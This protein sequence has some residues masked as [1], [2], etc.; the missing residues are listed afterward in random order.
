MRTII[1]ASILAFTCCLKANA[2]EIKPVSWTYVANKTGQ[3]EAEIYITAIIDR[4]YKI[5]SL[6]MEDGGP[7]KT[8]IVFRPSKAYKL[9]GNI[10]EPVPINVYSDVFKMNISYFEEK[11]VFK[12]KIR[13]NASKVTIKGYVEF[14][15]ENN[16][17]CLPPDKD[18]FTLLIN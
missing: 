11:V 3:N 16:S 10:S 4:G 7:I 9:I 1:I 14:M 8:C 13:L 17:I 18:N 12:Q 5:Y 15:S 2:Q 6:N